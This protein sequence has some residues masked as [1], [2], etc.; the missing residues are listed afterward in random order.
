M[1]NKRLIIIL[2]IATTLLLAP[3]AAM[4]FS[5]EV[6]WSLFDFV[7]AGILLYGTGLSIEFVLRKVKQTKFR[8]LISLLILAALVL[9]WAELAVGIFGAPFAGS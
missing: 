6:N 1:E 7:I 9:V 3:L 8:I 4:Q 2:S 5:S